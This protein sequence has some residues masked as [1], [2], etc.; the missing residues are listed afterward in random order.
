[1]PATSRAVPVFD[2]HNDTL[3]DLAGSAR[4]FFERS[5]SGHKHRKKSPRQ[6]ARARARQINVPGFRSLKKTMGPAARWRHEPR[7]PPR[8]G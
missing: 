3:L 6:I 1:M 5:E 2:G 7:P 4:S 8:A